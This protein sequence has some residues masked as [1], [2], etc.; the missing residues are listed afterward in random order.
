MPLP[1]HNIDELHSLK[2]RNRGVAPSLPGTLGVLLI[3]ADQICQ[4]DGF[5]P[6]TRKEEVWDFF[7]KFGAQS[8]KQEVFNG[9]FMYMMYMFRCVYR[10]PGVPYAKCVF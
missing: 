10:L 9:F 3:S 2:A 8:F 6:D 7:Q 5:Y 4:V 1:S